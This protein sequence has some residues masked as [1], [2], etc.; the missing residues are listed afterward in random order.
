[1][2]ITNAQRNDEG[3]RRKKKNEGINRRKATLIK[4]AYELGEVDGI[5]IALFICKHGRYTTWLIYLSLLELRLGS[6]TLFWRPSTI[7]LRFLERGL[8]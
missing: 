1:M 2:D 7:L 3:K 6:R 8:G 4:K 5:E